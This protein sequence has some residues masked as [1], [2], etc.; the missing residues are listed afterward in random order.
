MSSTIETAWCFFDM[1]LVDSYLH[2]LKRVLQCSGNIQ[3]FPNITGE[4]RHLYS[5]LEDAAV[6]VR[7]PKRST[8]GR[9]FNQTQIEASRHECLTTRFATCFS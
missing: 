2:C 6:N 3:Q 7:E 1:S 8:I 9:S 5:R 4:L